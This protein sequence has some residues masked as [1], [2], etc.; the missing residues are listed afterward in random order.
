MGTLQK[1]RFE[2][3]SVARTRLMAGTQ[4]KKALHVSQPRHLTCMRGRRGSPLGHMP[5]L[6]AIGIDGVK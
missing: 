6:A 4:G 3:K 1:K 5:S 2:G